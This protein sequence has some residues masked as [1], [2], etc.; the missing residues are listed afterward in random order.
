MT[1]D[2]SKPSPTQAAQ[3]SPSLLVSGLD[4]LGLVVVLFG[5]LLGFHVRWTG[6]TPTKVSLGSMDALSPNGSLMATTD[7]YVA[8]VYD[9]EKGRFLYLL[10]DEVCSLEFSTDGRMLLMAEPEGVVDPIRNVL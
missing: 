9:L 5:L 1:V 4:E 10:H 3:P 8:G 7:N 2:D 6:E